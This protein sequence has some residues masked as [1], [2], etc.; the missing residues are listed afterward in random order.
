MPKTLKIYEL[1]G[2]DGGLI[3]TGSIQEIADHM[4]VDPTYVRKQY[5]KG[6]FSNGCMVVS[7]NEER[8]LHNSN[9]L[10]RVQS[11]GVPEGGF[12]PEDLQKVRRV[13]RIGDQVITDTRILTVT[14]LYRHIFTAEYKGVSYAFQ[15]ADILRKKA[16]VRRKH[17]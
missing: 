16:K 11:E 4:G 2:G 5:R 15:Y 17:V 8:I 3:L 9:Y 1:Y 10:T 13:L 14:G 6:R 7:T 12:D